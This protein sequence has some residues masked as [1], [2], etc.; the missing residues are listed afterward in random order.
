[1]FFA[2]EPAFSELLLSA[3]FCVHF[4]TRYPYGFMRLSTQ[5]DLSSRRPSRS[6]SLFMKMVPPFPLIPKCYSR[7]FPNMYSPGSL[8]SGSFLP[9]DHGKGMTNFL[10]G[11]AGTCEQRSR[12]RSMRLLYL[13]FFSFIFGCFSRRVFMK[14]TRLR[15]LHSRPA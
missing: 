9:V 13:F 6:L 5:S 3:G 10:D 1:M 4:F 14:A 15:V 12:F 11:L 7:A 8:C 2:C